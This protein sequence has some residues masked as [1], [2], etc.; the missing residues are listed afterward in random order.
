M[1]CIDTKTLSINRVS[2]KEMS[3]KF[4]NG[5]HFI[6][7]EE[8][9]LDSPLSN[10]QLVDLYNS[11]AEKP[12]KRFSNR[13][14]AVRRVWSMMRVKVAGEEC[15]KLTPRKL[16]RPRGTGKFAGTRVFAKWE[17]NPRKRI[18]SFGWKSYEIIRGK[19]EG[20]PYEEY[21]EAGGRP[22]DLQWDINRGW[23]EA[24]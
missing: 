23:A 1:F 22:Q 18:N 3:R 14:V 19:P 4:G 13:I 6:A 5:V 20:V 17:K 24:K 15:K 7:S 12:T 16:G 2:S 8:D 9:L 11:L 10:Q 21:I